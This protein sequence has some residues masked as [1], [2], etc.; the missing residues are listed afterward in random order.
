MCVS[1]SGR[2]NGI[3]AERKKSENKC[4]VYLCTRRCVRAWRI[5]GRAVHEK[6]ERRNNNKSRTRVVHHHSTR[7]FRQSVP[8]EYN[9]HH[10]LTALFNESN[11][12]FMEFI[13]ISLPLLLHLPPP[14]YLQCIHCTIYLLHASIQL[15]SVPMS[16]I[17]GRLLA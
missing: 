3:S 10:S 16:A 4:C 5:C 11:E 8:N 1:T 2:K 15:R 17:T 9:M 13:S 12:L 7:F 14:I 6:Q